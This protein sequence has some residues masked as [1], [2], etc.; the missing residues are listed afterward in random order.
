MG[1]GYYSTLELILP[2]PIRVLPYG[3]LTAQAGSNHYS[4]V[5]PKN[6]VVKRKKLSPEKIKVGVGWGGLKDHSMA[7]S[8][9]GDVNKKLV[10]TEVTEW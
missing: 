6:W 10:I 4:L 9:C 3:L 8:S 2:W 7:G 5:R 1:Q